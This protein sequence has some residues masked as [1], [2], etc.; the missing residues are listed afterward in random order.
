M[1]RIS[2]L[3]LII[4][5]AALVIISVGTILI[6]TGR[7]QN[8]LIAEIYSDRQLIRTIDLNKVTDSYTIELPHNTVLV[9]HG[10][11]S[12]K[13]ADCPDQVCV[14]QGKIKNGT[15]PIVCLPNKVE[16]KITSKSDIDAVTGR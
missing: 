11:I 13:S 2:S 7:S 10:Q 1:K 3:K 8:V 6:M 5:F 9:E 4:I 12:M 16:I 14:K 15:Y